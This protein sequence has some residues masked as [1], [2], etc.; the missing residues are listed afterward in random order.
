MFTNVLINEKQDCQVSRTKPETS[1]LSSI[2]EMFNLE[3]LNQDNNIHVC[4]EYQ[5]FVVKQYCQQ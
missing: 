5:F 2:S 4:M 1:V 3:M